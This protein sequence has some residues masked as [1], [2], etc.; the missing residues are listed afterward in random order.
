MNQSSKSQPSFASDNFA[1]DAFISRLHEL[2]GH[3]PTFVQLRPIL[4]GG[5]GLPACNC[6]GVKP[7]PGPGKHPAE[8]WA[9]APAGFQSRG[10][11]GHALLT[12]PRSGVIVIDIDVDA[13]KGKDGEKDWR[14][15]LARL[16]LAGFTD[17]NEDVTSGNGE[18]RHI[19]FHAPADFDV[20]TDRDW[21]PFGEKVS[22]DVR[23]GGG[24]AYLPG[25]AHKSGGR[26]MAGPR[27]MVHELPPE[28][29]ALLEARDTVAD[30]SDVGPAPG[31]LWLGV[32]PENED[33]AV[34]LLAAAWPKRNR[35][36]AARGLAGAMY[37]A[38][39]P[40]PWAAEFVRKVSSLA[41]CERDALEAEKLVRDTYR[42]GSGGGKIA[43]WTTLRG[44]SPEPRKVDAAR[45]LLDATGEPIDLSGE[46]ANDDEP[47]PPAGLG[48][49]FGGWHTEPPPVDFLVEGLLPR[50]S[51]SKWFGHADSLKTWL[52]FSLGVSVSRGESW[53]GRF[54]CKKGRVVIVDYE[55]GTNNIRRRLFMLG[56]GNNDMLGSVSYPSCK[57]VDE[58]LWHE[59][60]KLAPD[61]VIIDS[62]RAG[63][64]GANENDSSEAIGPLL[65]A[66][67]FAE[68]TGAA[69]AFIHHAKKSSGGEVIQRGSAAIKD[70]VDCAFMVKAES[71]GKAS[72]RVS[73]ECEKPGDMPKPDAFEVEVEFDDDKKTAGLRLAG[74]ES[75]EKLSPKMVVYHALRDRGPFNSEEALRKATELGMGN[76]RSAWKELVGDGLAVVH[77]RKWR[78]DSKEARTTRMVD[79]TKRCAESPET[80]RR[81]TDAEFSK[82]CAVSVRDVEEAVAARVIVRGNAGVKSTLWVPG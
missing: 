52:L 30:V 67:K 69:V 19:Y 34:R 26:Y 63:N 15:L 76:L 60:F 18:G 46:P 44:L 20:K 77:E 79:Y 39:A 32:D 71:K 72:W 73:L 24:M 47:E 54:P 38:G 43:G 80:A 22:I 78:V 59:L 81:M 36:D 51:L 70:Q 75:G 14:G 1:R 12:G 66:G 11:H 50:G 68:L 28:L 42:K 4:N 35:H 58:G 62:L 16:A 53:L 21:K 64:P 56:A 61:L 57:T 7:C 65:L 49:T 10:E 27:F 2:S 82:T 23:G 3:V 37:H 45:G 33:A 40:A 13:A 6:N 31:K 17:R 48:V 8:L 9:D 5:N 74:K 41:G 29:A 25:S 55:T